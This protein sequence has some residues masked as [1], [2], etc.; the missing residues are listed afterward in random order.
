MVDGRKMRT[1]R[2][3]Q[4][5]SSAYKCHR[6]HC[7]PIPA[8]SNTNNNN[9]NDHGEKHCSSGRTQFDDIEM[10]GRRYLDRELVGE[11]SQLRIKKI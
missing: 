10:Y 4:I 8:N 3:D 6:H 7:L 1:T 9:N 2:P 11:Y 5:E